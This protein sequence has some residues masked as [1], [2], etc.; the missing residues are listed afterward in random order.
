M[1]VRVLFSHVKTFVTR[2][3]QDPRCISLPPLRAGQS[4]T[5]SAPNPGEARVPSPVRE[6]DRVRDPELYGLSAV[7]PRLWPASSGTFSSLTP[8]LSRTGEGARCGSRVRIVAPRDAIGSDRR[9]ALDRCEDRLADTL[10]VRRNIIIVDAQNLEAASHEHL[11]S[12]SIAR[13]L[14]IAPVRRPIDLD[15]EPGRETGEIRDRPADR[16][17]AA[18][19]PAIESAVAQGAPEARF[20]RRL[21]VPKRLRD[22][23]RLGHRERAAPTP[24]PPARR[25]PTARSAPR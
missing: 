8:T 4:H 14:D 20:G 21:P 23:A 17:L 22:A 19:L 16:E 12:P 6:R 1:G 10:K 7:L 25:S 13:P 5:P 11:G 18:E 24:P 9:P 2:C 15:D 3:A